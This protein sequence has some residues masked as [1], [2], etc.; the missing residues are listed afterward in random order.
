MNLIS[1]IFSLAPNPAKLF[2]EKSGILLERMLNE[3]KEET[4]DPI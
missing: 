4:T 2:M 1:R 3:R